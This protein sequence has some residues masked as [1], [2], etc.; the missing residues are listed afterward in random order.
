MWELQKAVEVSSC[1]LLDIF[2]YEDCGTLGGKSSQPRVME[3]PKIKPRTQTNQ[4][5]NGQKPISVSLYSKHSASCSVAGQEKGCKT[6][7]CL[8]C[9]PP[10][11]M[12]LP[13]SGRYGHKQIREHREASLLQLWNL[14]RLLTPREA[15]LCSE[16]PPCLHIAQ[17]INTEDTQKYSREQCQAL[18]E[19]LPPPPKKSCLSFH[20][21]V[22]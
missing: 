12:S 4:P 1:T 8:S 7:K 5:K 11:T 20:D 21:I 9:R 13:L 3:L 15:V 22:E 19:A 17:I 16:L 2:I 18:Q 10:L 6:F 14:L